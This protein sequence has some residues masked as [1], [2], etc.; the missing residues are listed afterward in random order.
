MILGCYFKDS[1]IYRLIGNLSY[2]KFYWNKSM[3][4]LLILCFEEM[5]WFGDVNEFK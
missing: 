1:K 2:L 4:L 5:E 3:V